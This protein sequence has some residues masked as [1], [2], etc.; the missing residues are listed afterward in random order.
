ML[1]GY[2]FV[3]HGLGCSFGCLN[4]AV[5]VGRNVNFAC[6]A[7]DRYLGQ[8]VDFCLDGGLKGGKGQSHSGQKLRNQAVFLLKQGKKQVCLLNLLVAVLLRDVLRALNGFQRFLGK[9][10][11]VHGNTLLSGNR[12]LLFIV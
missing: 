6:L 11:C 3:L 9:L 5:E 10:I 2:I 12:L 1:H 7:A 8:L 4:G